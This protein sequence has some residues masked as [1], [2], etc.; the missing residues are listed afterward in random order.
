MPENLRKYIINIK[1]VP[2]SSVKVL[3]MNYIYQMLK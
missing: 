2:K 1:H 3:K